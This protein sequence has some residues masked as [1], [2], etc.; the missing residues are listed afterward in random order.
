[1]IVVPVSLGERSYDVVVGA[2]AVEQLAAHLPRGAAR[3]AIVTQR[4]IP[5]EVDL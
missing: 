2:G 1:M 4:D 5:H 3:A